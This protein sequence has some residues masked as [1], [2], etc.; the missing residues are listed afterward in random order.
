MFKNYENGLSLKESLEEI[1]DK[2]VTFEKKE[3][4]W[5]KIEDVYDDIED[6]LS[7]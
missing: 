3:N 1:R 7:K 2:G 5:E 4:N 6:I